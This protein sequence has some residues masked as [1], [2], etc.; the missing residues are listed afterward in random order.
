MCADHLLRRVLF[1]RSDWYMQVRGHLPNSVGVACDQAS[2]L[3][4][5]GKSLHFG[6]GVNPPTPFA[7][8][9]HV[10]RTRRKGQRGKQPRN[11]RHICIG[12]LR[13]SGVWWRARRPQ[14]SA[15]GGD[16]RRKVLPNHCRSLLRLAPLHF[17]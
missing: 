14:T 10:A 11:H 1:A 4:D 17:A 12:S 6:E 5:E 15:V 7:G 13:C 8:P 2:G 9:S 3:G 16:L